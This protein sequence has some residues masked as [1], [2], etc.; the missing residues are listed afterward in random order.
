MEF[1]FN[2]LKVGFPPHVNYPG[3]GFAVFH[4]CVG[5]HKDPIVVTN[6]RDGLLLLLLLLS[7]LVR[8]TGHTKG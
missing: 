8:D 1:V 5:T 3:T 7:I 4:Y 6:A 2:S